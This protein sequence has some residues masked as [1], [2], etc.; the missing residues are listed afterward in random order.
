MFIRQEDLTLNWHGYKPF[1]WVHLIATGGREVI[2]D[3]LRWQPPPEE[4]LKVNVDASFKDG[5]AGLSMVARNSRKQV[6]HAG[7]MIVKCSNSQQAE[8]SGLL[9]AVRFAESINWKDLIL[10]SDAS[11]VVDAVLTNS[12]LQSVDT[13]T[14]QSTHTILKNIRG[15]LEWIPRV[16]NEL[17]DRLAKYALRCSTGFDADD[18]SS[19]THPSTYVVYDE[20]NPKKL[21]VPWP[22]HEKP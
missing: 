1:R 17:A 13:D 12:V 9:F 14:I 6:V 2:A 20:S 7:C 18:S 21:P 22:P 15:E 5:T 16:R 11:Q 8:A 19:K 4:K 10:E 3:G